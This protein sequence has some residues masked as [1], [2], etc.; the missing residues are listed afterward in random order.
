MTNDL[1]KWNHIIYIFF[2]KK[3]K[4]KF[5]Y[6]RLLIIVPYPNESNTFFKM[7]NKKN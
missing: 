6:E 5:L 3:N 2:T 7:Y 4:S 1:L